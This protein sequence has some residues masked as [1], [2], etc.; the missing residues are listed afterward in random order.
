MGD[1]LPNIDIPVGV[2]VDLYTLSGISAGDAIHV[3]NIGAYDVYLSVQSAQPSIDHDSYN[4]VQRGN[5]IRLQNAHGASGAWAFCNNIGG[6][7]AVGLAAQDGFYPLA[8]GGGSAPTVS[9]EN[10]TDSN[11][12]ADGTFTGEWVKTIGYGIVYVSVYSDVDS[13]EDG[14]IIEQSTN[15]TE[16]HFD[17]VFTI[18]AGVGKNFS[19]NPH[20]EYLRVR[21]INGSSPTTHF[22]LQT[23]F[24]HNGLDSSHRIK[25]D[26]NHDDDARLV[27]SILSVK[28]ND[29]DQYKNIERVNPMPIN[30]DLVYAQDVDLSLSSVYTFSGSPLDLFDDMYST[31]VDNTATNP[32]RIDIY[33]ERPIQTSNIGIGTA[34]GSFSNTVIKYGFVGIPVDFTLLDESADSTPK[35]FVVGPS[36]PIGLTHVK[37]EFHTA[38]TCTVSNIQSG[39]NRSVTAQLRGLTED[40]EIIDVGA[41]TGGNLK[42]S[43]QEYGDTPAIDAFDRLR[44]SHPYTI[45][46]SKQLWDDQPLFFDENLGGSATSTHSTV[47]A[48]VQLAVTAS[49]SDYA[50]RQ[51]KQRFNYQPG[52]STLILLTFLATQETGITKRIGFFDGTGGTFMT[53]NDGIFFEVNDTTCSWNIAKNGSTTETVTQANWNYDPMD[54]TGPS[55]VTLDLDATQIAIIDFEYLGV[56]RVRVGFVV[57]GIIRYVNYF[58]HAND[59]T[60]TTV[61]MSSPNQPIRYDIQSDGTGAGSIDHI[62][63][64][65]MSEGGIELTGISRSIDTAST[66]LDAN[67]ANT[68]YVLL[69]LRLKTTHLDL[70]VLPQSFSMISQTNDDFQILLLMSP[71]Y[72]GTLTYNDIPNSGC[73]YAAGVTANDITD[74][75]TKLHSSYAKS[76]GSTTANIVTNLRIGSLI[77][78]T[79]DEL[80]LAVRPLSANADYHGALVFRELL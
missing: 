4:V 60:F 8:I 50:I 9:P 20:A 43:L 54:G 71:T 23:I 31:I 47:H 7:V 57:D 69:S 56:G 58:N 73:Q 37:F 36:S 13:A 28:S 51:T 17:D 10:S 33:F 49:A 34:S 32:K 75:G 42:V 65:V 66:H 35:T 24:K 41:T 2:W 40:N 64:T 11:I 55:G 12:I 61:Y 27:K 52:K 77:D 29:L 45:F 48:R 15:G 79:R 14:L 25:D 46:D 63:G 67:T 3:E 53:P 78:G 68:I 26:I 30:G 16:A 70:T 59:S 1:N 38:N 18:A 44:V 39:T 6:K 76:Q 19:I 22:H 21:Y 72:N 5:G 62:C 80:I 74:V